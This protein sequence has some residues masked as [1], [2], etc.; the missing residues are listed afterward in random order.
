M[1]QLT[2]DLHQSGAAFPF[3]REASDLWHNFRTVSG[4]TP[5]SRA[6][7]YGIYCLPNGK[8][9]IG[10]T[11]ISVAKRL[12]QHRGVARSA[13]PK[14]RNALIK[15]GFGNF[16]V[17]PLFYCIVDDTTEL[18]YIEQ[19]LISAYSASGR[20]G[21]NTN[22]SAGRVGPFGPEFG[23]IISA[24]KKEHF[25]DPENLARHK[26]RQKKVFARPEV[27]AKL[28]TSLTAYFANPEARAKNS[29]AVMQAYSDP[30]VRAKVSAGQR[31]RFADPE[32]RAAT[33]AATKAAMARPEVL[34]KVSKASAETWKD[35]QVRQRRMSTMSALRKVEWQD[36]QIRA[37]RLAALK[38]SWKNPEFRAKRLAGMKAA[39]ARGA[40]D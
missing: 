21:F 28:S 38:A 7:A 34:E 22:L 14:F 35:P 26:A 9:Y 6:G 23:V 40:A 15:Y 10:V 18:P 2:L 24:A 13:G 17:V 32:A 12:D 3:G 37:K 11:G 8:W 29:A 36:P 16:I 39:R 5:L 30:V 31:K 33:S 19:A 1:I 4:N 25:S 27:R 20:T